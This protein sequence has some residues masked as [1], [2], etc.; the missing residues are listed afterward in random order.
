LLK[1]AAIISDFIMLNL[2]LIPEEHRELYYIYKCETS[3]NFTSLQE[4]VYVV[5]TEQKKRLKKMKKE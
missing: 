4:R 2:P 3:D 5:E 1:I